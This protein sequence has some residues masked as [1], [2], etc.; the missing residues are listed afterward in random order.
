M[1]PKF[2]KVRKF[3]L[4]EVRHHGTAEY[5]Q[6]SST[7]ACIRSTETIATSI[8]LQQLSKSRSISKSILS[9]TVWAVSRTR[10]HNCDRSN[11]TC[12]RV[13]TDSCGSRL[14]W[15]SSVGLLRHLVLLLL[16]RRNCIFSGW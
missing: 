6:P 1:K 2:L 3:H 14:S 10:Q 8:Q 16:V 12:I 5:W 4:G 11:Q 13:S 15:A 9:R 7:P